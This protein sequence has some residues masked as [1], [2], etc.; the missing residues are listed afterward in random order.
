MGEMLLVNVQGWDAQPTIA[1]VSEQ[2][3][4][5]ISAF[6]AEFGVVLV[7]VENNVYTVRIRADAADKIP[8]DARGASGPFSDPRIAPFGPPDDGDGPGND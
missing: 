2:L 1:Q 5:P 3:S 6:D 7:D 4:V 8:G